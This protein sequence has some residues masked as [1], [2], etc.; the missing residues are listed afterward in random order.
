MTEDSSHQGK[1]P[2]WLYIVPLHLIGILLY[3]AS[4]Q[5]TFGDL[6][7][8]FSSFLVQSFKETLQYCDEWGKFTTG[9]EAVSQSSS[10]GVNSGGLYKF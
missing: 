5:I 7:T 8:R 2:F 10:D 6:P 3:V 9:S 1:V 4:A